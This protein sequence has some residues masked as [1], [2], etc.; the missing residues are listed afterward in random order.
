MAGQKKIS[1]V[2]PVYNVEPYLEECIKSVLCQTCSPW[3]IILV[4]DGSADG[5]G[6]ICDRHARNNSRIKVIHTDHNGPS[7]ARNAGIRIA[8]G[9]YL[10]FIDSD[11]MVHPD[12]LKIMLELSEKYDADLVACDFV[13]SAE[14]FWNHKDGTE[15]DE[16]SVGE[17]KTQT[18][19][20]NNRE[21]IIEVRRGRDVLE[22]MNT[23]DVVITVVWNKLYDRKFFHEYGLR[24]PEGKIHEDMFF[25][26]QVLYYSNTMVLTDR[27]LYFYRQ[28]PESIMTSSFTLKKLDVLESIEFRIR[29]F[30]ELHYD[31]LKYTEYEG[32]IRK[33]R[34]LYGCMKTEG[35]EKYRGDMAGL[36]K[37]AWHLL[38]NRDAMCHISW[39]CRVK[40]AVF[41]ILRF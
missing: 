19:A 10:A 24:F 14:A 29:Y 18:D 26:P 13:R 21:G 16:K 11:D 7:A 8:G 28:R 3:E 35:K 31:S 27:K 34:F 12:Y 37:K 22:Q 39:K 1:V 9:D 2:I 23:N 17:R 30:D 36:R 5:S 4:D 20:E 33:I 32:Y 6:E 40:L 25:T 15:T 41:L 38:K